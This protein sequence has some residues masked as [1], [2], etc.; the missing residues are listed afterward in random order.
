MAHT[1]GDHHDHTHQEPAAS[2]REIYDALLEEITYVDS[3]LL[4]LLAER[5]SLSAEVGMLR[6]EVAEAGGAAL[7]MGEGTHPAG[8]L[9]AGLQQG[10]PLE[11]IE[12]LFTVIQR[13]AVA[14]EIAVIKGELAMYRHDSSA[15]EG[16][17]EDGEDANR[18]DEEF[19][20][21][22][23]ALL[24]RLSNPEK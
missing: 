7:P 14:T 9:T 24:R 13:H 16:H 22:D 4:E 10:L 17:D 3:Q 21:A 6:K 18:Q 20:E 11:F 15:D 5:L 1:H 23:I 19:S 2:P 12:E 8:L